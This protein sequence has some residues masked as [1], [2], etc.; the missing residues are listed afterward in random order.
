[1]KTAMTTTTEQQVLRVCPESIG[2]KTLTIEQV[3]RKIETSRRGK[4]KRHQEGLCGPYS[5]IC[6]DCAK[7][8]F[9]IYMRWVREQDAPRQDEDF[10]VY[11]RRVA[12]MA[13]ELENNE[14]PSLWGDEWAHASMTRIR[15]AGSPARGI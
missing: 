5:S 7:S 15:E 13:A 11:W 2:M 4:S 1:M 8:Q 10:C 6:S 3:E 12:T 9:E 14:S